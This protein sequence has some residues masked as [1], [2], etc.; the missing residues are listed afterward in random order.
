MK[1]RHLVAGFAIVIL[2]VI[3]FSSFASAMSVRTTDISVG[4]GAKLTA[5]AYGNGTFMEVWYSYD[6]RYMNATVVNSTTGAVIK[7]GTISTDVYTHYGVPTIRPAIAYV[8]DSDTFVIAWVNSSSYLE[9]IGVNS[10]LDVTFPETTINDTTGVSY[11]GIAMAAGADK[12]F[13]VWSDSSYHLEGR[14]MNNT[15][16]GPVFRISNFDSKYQQ[17]PWIAYDPGTNNFMVVWVNYTAYYNITGKLFNAETMSNVTGDILIANAYA[18]SSSYTA[19][20]VSGGNSEFFV[21]YVTYYSPYN[22]TGKIYSATSGDLIEGPIHIGATYYHGRSPM[23]SV[24]NGNAFVVTWSNSTEAILARAYSTDGSPYTDVQIIYNGTN[25]GNPNIAYDPDD[26]MYYFSW[27]E[28]Q[29]SGTPYAL[30]ASIWSEDEF[31]PEFGLIAPVAAIAIVGI[32][33]AR[34]R[35]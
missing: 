20:T 34:R 15:F 33:I 24:F 19:P 35:H 26:G 29:G 18:D 23:P 12:V 14:F 2:S 28:Y 8:P 30:S 32:I 5:V 16:T 6:G 27:T 22:I 31:I 4:N 9:A 17:N 21:T 25:G 7:T 3:I 13:F 11:K 10:T 1:V